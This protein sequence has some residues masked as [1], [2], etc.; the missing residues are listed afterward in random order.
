MMIQDGALWW[1]QKWPVSRIED[2]NRYKTTVGHGWYGPRTIHIVKANAFGMAV[3]D[4]YRKVITR[5]EER[6]DYLKSELRD[7]N[8]SADLWKN[9]PSNYQALQ[10]NELPNGLDSLA[11]ITV[12]VRRPE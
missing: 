2:S 3:M 10:F 12:E 5:N 11:S 1:P 8:L 9:M 4:F 7:V 6:T